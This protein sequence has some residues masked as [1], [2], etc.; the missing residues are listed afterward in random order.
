[1]MSI[2]LQP[3]GMFRSWDTYLLYPPTCL[4][5][6]LLPES[7]YRFNP[8]PN[9]C[10]RNLDISPAGQSVPRSPRVERTA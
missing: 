7:K 3:E 5:S 2:F 4:A 9:P 1:M 6:R 8:N 10:L